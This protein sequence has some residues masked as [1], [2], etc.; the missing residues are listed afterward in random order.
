MSDRNAAQTQTQTNAPSWL[1]PLTLV[2]ASQSAVRRLLLQS[3]GIPLDIHPADIDERAIEDR[4]KDGAPADIAALLAR[5]KA[6]AVSAALPGRLVVGADQVLAL[7]TQRFNKP[8]SRAAAAD[9]LKTLR[10]RTHALHAAVAVARDGKIL[11]AHGDIARLTMRDFSDAFLES[12]L[13]SAGDSLTASVGA[14]ALESVGVQL[15]SRIDGD[16]FTILGLPLIPL[17]DFLRGE[18]ALQ[19]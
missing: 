12:Y 15:F 1:A 8:P 9:Q 10:G 19:R 14:Y 18:G 3:A 7:G 5:E 13:A 16:Y 2:L 4:Q 17:L 11:F 6:L